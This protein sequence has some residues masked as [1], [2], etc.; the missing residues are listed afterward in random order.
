MKGGT[1]KPRK[2]VEKIT[3]YKK[4]ESPRIFRIR[5]DL[6]ENF[7]GCSPKVVDLFEKSRLLF[8]ECVSCYPVYGLLEQ[9]IAEYHHVNPENI[10]LTNGAQDAVRCIIDTYVE[11]GD[12]VVIP[13][14]A[15]PLCEN[16][17]ILREGIINPILYNKDFSFPLP[18][19]LHAVKDTPKMV[20]I[21]NPHDLM[22]TSAEKT[23]LTTLLQHKDTIFLVDETYSDFA[24]VTNVKLVEDFPNLF[25]V[26]SFS[27]SHGL[28]GLRLGY[29]VSDSRNIK[30]VEKVRLPFSVNTLADMA[31]DVSLDEEYIEEVVE[32]IAQ[33]KAFLDKG[34][35]ALGAQTSRT[36]TNF[37]L[38]DFGEECNKIYQ[39]LHKRDVLVTNLSD[40]PLLKG[41]LR[42]TVGSRDDNEILLEELR[43]ILSPEAILFGIGGV[44]VD[45][46][47]S[48]IL[49]AQKAAEYFLDK[50]VEFEDI[51]DWRM[52]VN[53]SSHWEIAK[54]AVDSKEV[55]VPQEFIIEKFQQILVD[56]SFD[57]LIQN[58]NLIID[59]NVLERLREDY[60]LGIVT[61]RP[62]K[63]ALYTLNRFHLEEYFDTV[64]TGEDVQ[65]KY[66][67]EPDGIRQALRNLQVNRAV[68]VGNTYIDI[69]AAKSAGIVPIVIIPPGYEEWEEVFEEMDVRH[70]IKTADQVQ[71]VLW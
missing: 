41:Y 7:L 44:L 23:Y 18:A 1:M 2:E 68:F 56:D 37:V 70:F 58:E 3:G 5:L 69:M 55:E 34:L 24:G 62:E 29:V 51:E 36:D 47:N 21:V 14:P 30:N 52:M 4:V 17:V 19:L 42:I 13:S 57:G 20:I 28:A 32:K 53:Y 38:A 63:E 31:A 15:S 11:K 59:T 71:K 61:N 27:I 9:K 50:G 12:T 10:L 49:A 54:V 65:G 48:Y 25:V 40:Y 60:K 66:K 35:L 16:L 8:P 67:P 33:E 6:N 45:E 39:T 26:R 46:C 64:V 43:E 22:G